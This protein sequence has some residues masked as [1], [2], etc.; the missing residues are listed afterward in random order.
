MLLVNRRRASLVCLENNWDGGTSSAP[1][2]SRSIPA[3]KLG[4]IST[5]L[6]W[7]AVKQISVAPKPGNARVNQIKGTGKPA[8]VPMNQIIA[9]VNQI[10]PPGNQ[11]NALGNQIIADLKEISAGM[12]QTSA[13]GKLVSAAMKP[14]K[15]PGKRIVLKSKRLAPCTILVEFPSTFRTSAPLELPG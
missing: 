5:K 1:L 4:R 6:V 7:I 11:I 15:A 12:K 3:P 2:V 8:S 14:V 13:D 10:S 9:E